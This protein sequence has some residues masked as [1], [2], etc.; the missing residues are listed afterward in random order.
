LADKIIKLCHQHGW[1]TPYGNDYFFTSFHFSIEVSAN[2]QTDAAHEYFELGLAK[3]PDKDSVWKVPGTM[4]F[5]TAATNLLASQ[6][7]ISLRDDTCFQLYQITDQEQR[8][9]SPVL[10]SPGDVHTCISRK[11]RQTLADDGVAVT[12]ERIGAM[13][14]GFYASAPAAEPPKLLGQPGDLD[15]CLQRASIR[16]DAA[17]AFPNIRMFLDRLNDGAAF[18]AWWYGAYSG[19]NKGRQMLYI[20]DRQGQGGKSKIL[21]TLAE[22]LFGN[23]IYTSFP[24]TANFAST[25]MTSHFVGKRLVV[26]GDNKDAYVLHRGTLKEISGDDKLYVDPKYQQPFSTTIECRVCVAANVAPFIIN[27]VHNTSRTLF[28]VLEPLTIADQDRDVAYAEK[29]AAELPGFLAYAQAQY[30]RLCPNDYA[31]ETNDA[32]KAATELR[33]QHCATMHVAVFE[34][35]FVPDP[36]GSLTHRDWTHVLREMKLDRHKGEDLFQWILASHNVT[37][38]AMPNK[39]GGWYLDGIR[40]KTATDK[41]HT[42]NGEEKGGFDA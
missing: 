16:P 13:L 18:S 9:V 42:I 22:S 24:P 34:E 31:I 25:H 4:G 12:H 40:L 35:Y 11:V 5:Q 6:F 26:I 38:F 17:I 33:I 3:P 37:Q 41:R 7:I 20:F 8:T 30:E 21:G 27:A 39:G 14:T 32:V 36:Q 1:P 19:R 2:W 28:L 10:G 15:W 23:R 29:C